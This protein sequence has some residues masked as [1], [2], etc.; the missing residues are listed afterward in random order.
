MDSRDGIVDDDT[1]DANADFRRCGIDATCPRM[2]WVFGAGCKLMFSDPYDVVGRI[3]CA[4]DRSLF[5]IIRVHYAASS[6]RTHHLRRR[7]FGAFGSQ[8]LSQTLCL[9]ILIAFCCVFIHRR[10][11]L[12]KLSPFEV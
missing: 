10:N 8:V 5:R 11:F 1:S 2:Y 6:F 4:V 7:E 9:M 3:F 12:S